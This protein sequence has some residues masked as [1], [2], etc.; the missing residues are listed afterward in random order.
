M[1]SNNYLSIY[2]KSFNWAGFFL[3]KK[4]YIKCSALYD[5]CRT[6]DN[7]A[8]S[9]ENLNLKKKKLISFKNSFNNKQ[10]DNPIIKN[11]WELINDYKISTKIINDLFD[12]AESDLK[13]KIQLNS[14]KDLLVYSYRVAGTVGLMM[15]KILRVKNKEA[16]KGAI[17]LG[18]AMQLTN[19]AR[20]VVEDKNKNRQYINFDFSSIKN[21]ISLSE[22]F[23][24]KS[25]KAISSIPLKSRFSVIVARRVYKK[26][27]LKILEKRNIDNYVKAGKIYVSFMGKLIETILSIFDFFK[28]LTIKEFNYD[29]EKEHS[30]ISE[31]IKIHERI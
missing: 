11:M 24:E 28:L 9:S 31:E 17:D 16:L 13:D 1:S 7:I 6:V 25:F 30:I 19:I 5:F 4:I 2:A 3:P 27:G 18:I 14:K 8:D 20:D 15:S 23:Y 12:G 29:N 10:D 26:I 21:T 22:T